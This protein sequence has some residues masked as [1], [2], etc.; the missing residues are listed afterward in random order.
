MSP[1]LEELGLLW[2]NLWNISFL[3]LV[4]HPPGGMELDYIANLCL[5]PS[6]CGFFLMSLVAE[7][8]LWQLLL[9]VINGR[10]AD[11]C[12]FG[13]LGREGE[14]RIILLFHLGQSKQ[15]YLKKEKKKSLTIP[16]PF[17]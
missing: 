5:L 16:P 6:H 7:Y 2:K 14:L 1:A 4:P 9:F 10:S 15:K 13:A 3:L 17:L 8:L 12:D 11:G